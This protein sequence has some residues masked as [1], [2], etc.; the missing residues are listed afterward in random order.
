MS[1]NDAGYQAIRFHPDTHLPQ[2]TQDCTGCGLCVSVCPVIDCITMVNKSDV[3]VV[4]RGSY[5]ETIQMDWNSLNGTN[6]DR[7]DAHEQEDDDDFMKPPDEL[8]K[9]MQANQLATPFVPSFPVN[10]NYVRPK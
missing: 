7:H 2:V 4:D 10:L 1:C 5:K 9:Q 3:H 8:L 6:N